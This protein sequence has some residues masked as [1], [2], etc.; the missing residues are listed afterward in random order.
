MFIKITVGMPES[1]SKDQD[2]EEGLRW[3]RH[4]RFLIAQK[5]A[6]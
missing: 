6:V 5:K 4:K 1:N 2:G 3:Y